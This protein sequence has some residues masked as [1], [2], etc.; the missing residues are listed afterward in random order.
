[1]TPQLYV[2]V[3]ADVEEVARRVIGC[4]I[5]VHRIL[6]P[7][8]KER[9]YQEAMCLEMNADKLS[10][11]REKEVTVRYRNWEIPGHRLDLVVEGK[12]VLELKAVRRLKEIH[13]RQVVSYLKASN[14]RLGIL[15]N[16]NTNLLRDGTRRVIL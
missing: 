12:I 14:L 1:M 13:R 5:K 6:G 8:F 15:M 10:F 11:E 16:F 2:P 9:I 4:G 7:G 3:P